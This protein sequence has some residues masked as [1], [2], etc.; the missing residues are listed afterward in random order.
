LIGEGLEHNFDLVKDRFGDIAHVREFNVGDY[1]Y[2]ALMKLFNDM[3]Y[4]GWILLEARTD[5]EDKVAA[6]TEQRRIFEQLASR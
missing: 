3:E 2:S 5:P 1:P 4:R 6:M